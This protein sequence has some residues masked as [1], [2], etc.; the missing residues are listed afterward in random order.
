MAFSQC[1]RA[2]TLN[3]TL[4]CPTL[5]PSPHVL[6]DS[7]IIPAAGESTENAYPMSHLANIWAY[8]QLPIVDLYK[9][10]NSLYS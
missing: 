5:P 1:A 3:P 10:T 9:V 4:P 6:S 8:M 7:S 2:Y